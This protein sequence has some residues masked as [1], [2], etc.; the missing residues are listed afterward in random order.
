MSDSI[1]TGAKLTPETFA[2]FIERLKYHNQGEGVNE[3]CTADAIFIVQRKRLVS[4]ID[5][6]YTDQLMIWCDDCKWFS[7]Q[8]YWDDMDSDGRVMLNKNH[9]NGAISNS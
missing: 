8:E 2:D 9:R 7:I 3:H 4:G 5:T 6:D 1:A